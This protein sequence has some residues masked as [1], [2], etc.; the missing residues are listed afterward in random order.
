[1]T[2]VIYIGVVVAFFLVS[3]LYAYWCERL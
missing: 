1:M 3:E 2:D